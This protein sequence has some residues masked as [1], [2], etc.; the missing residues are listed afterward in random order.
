MTV[1]NLQCLVTT[2]DTIEIV[3]QI[4]NF[5]HSKGGISNSISIGEASSMLRQRELSVDHL[6]R[7]K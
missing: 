7:K 2:S 3:L 6:Q 5:H 4:A 1:Y